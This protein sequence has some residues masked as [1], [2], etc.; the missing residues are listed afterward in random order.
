MVTGAT[1]DRAMVGIALLTLVPGELG[2]SETYVRELLRALARGGELDYRVLLPPVAPTARAG[3]RRRSRPSTARRG[4]C[5][6][7]SRRWRWRRGAAGAAARAARGRRRRALPADA[8]ASRGRAAEGRDAARPAAPRPAGA[9]PAAERAFRVGR[10]APLGARRA[11]R[12]HDQL[13][14]PR[15]RG[16]AARA[17]PGAGA[18]RSTSGSTTSGSA[19]RRVEREPFLLYPARRWPHKNHE[20]LFEAFALLRRER[21][22]LRLVLTGGGDSARLPDGVEVR[23]ARADGRARRRCTAR[24][25]ALVF[26]SL[27]EGFGQPPLEAMACGCPVACSDVASL[28]EV[29]GDAARLFDPNDPS[30]IAAAVLDVLAARRSGRRAASSGRSS[31][32][33]RRPPAPTRTS[34]ASCSDRVRSRVRAGPN[35][36]EV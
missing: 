31:S 35:R 30:A 6:S 25:S 1:Y 10:L 28:P 21:P 27:Y 18:R 5:R 9:V 34:T 19:R 16:R 11:T 2:G 33:G 4:R 7:G 3:C 17:R 20:R 12:D 32:R 13:V 23:G 29:V 8:R 36:R 22:E 26:P 14:R 15:P 24:A